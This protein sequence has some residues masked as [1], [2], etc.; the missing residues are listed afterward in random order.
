MNPT[1]VE[2]LCNIARISALGGGG[3]LPASHSVTCKV[4]NTQHFVGVWDMVE[5]ISKHLGEVAFHALPLTKMYNFFD[6][7]EYSTFKEVLNDKIIMAQSTERATPKDDDIGPSM[8][9]LKGN[10]EDEDERTS[11]RTRRHS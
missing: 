3:F 7:Q 6:Y 1:A 2:V 11:R 9:L 10:Q 8:L 5:L 4:A